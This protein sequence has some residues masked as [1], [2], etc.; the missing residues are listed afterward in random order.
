MRQVKVWVLSDNTAGPPAFEAEHGLSLMVEVDGRKLLLDAGQ[1]GSAVRNADRLGL[2]WRQVE[3]VALSH[4]HYDH[5]AGL[6]LVLQRTGPRKVVHHPHVFRAKYYKLGEVVRYIGVPWRREF[7]ES[8]GAM[9]EKNTGPVQLLE[10]VWLTGEV[11]RVT[12]YEPGDTNL[13]TEAGGEIVTDPLLDDQAMV[14]DTGEGLVIVLGCAHSGT[15]NTCRYARE[16]TGVERILAVVG[17]S[18]LAFLGKEQLE[19]TIQALREMDPV[20]LAFSHC[21]GQAASR[22]LA[23]AFGDR[24][25]F[26]QTGAC[27]VMDDS[28]I[29]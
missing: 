22:E 27:L 4:G 16:I 19:R 13:K 25:I 21:T 29:G 8:A 28:T 14:V 2:D 23:A 18:H 12:D 5:T 26:N 15:V 17:G 6:P 24:F 20:L 3:A 9:L 11:P 7:L 1:T 10:G